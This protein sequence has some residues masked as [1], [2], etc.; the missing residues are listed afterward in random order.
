MLS[1]TKKE[2]KEVKIKTSSECGMCK[3]RIEGKLDYTKGIKNS[4]LD[5]DSKV[6]TVKYDPNKITVEQI[7][8]IVVELGYDADDQKANTEAQQNLPKCCQPHGMG[9]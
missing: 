9:K 5:I 2:W 7:K 6:L 8:T 1:F 4:N 3:E